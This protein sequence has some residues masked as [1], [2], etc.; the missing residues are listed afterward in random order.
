M[1]VQQKMQTT[2][3][4]NIWEA[5]SPEEEKPI[6]LEDKLEKLKEKHDETKKGKRTHK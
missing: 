6:T 1:I 4:E 3:G 5:P 2:K